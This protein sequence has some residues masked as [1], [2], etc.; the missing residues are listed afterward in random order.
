MGTYS[1]SATTQS[2]PIG[3]AANLPAI[4]GKSSARRPQ[5]LLS[6]DVLRGLTVALMIL[7]NNAGD[8]A[9]SYAQLRHSVWNG[10]TV[11]DLVFPLFLFIVGAS[12]VLAFG[13]RLDRGA[14]RRTILLQLGKRSA[15]IALI[16]LLLNALPFFDLG[17]LRYYGVMQRIALCYALAGTIY[18]A[19]RVKASVAAAILLLTLYWWLLTHVP[20]PGA[21]M[22]GVTIG[23]LDKFGNLTAWLDRLLIPAAHLY[24]HSVY[25]PEG[26]LSTLPAVASTLLGVLAAA[27]LRN[28]RPVRQK[29]VVLFAAGILLLNGGLVWSQSFPLN[30]RLWTSSFVLFTA[31][32]SAALL[33]AIY[34]LVDGPL[35][36]RRGLTPWQAFGTNAL[37][38]YVLSEVL[39]IVIGAIALP[40]GRNLQQLLYS[41]LPRWLG[42]APTV[43]LIYSILF[44]VACYLP[45][46]IL[47]RKRIF[48]KL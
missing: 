33:A 8:G 16:G 47:Y 21:G 40:G 12:I 2:D 32:L 34:W 35:Q 41:L 9:V 1:S 39:A 42:P 46:L 28:D 29:A 4:S 24:H 37:T 43:S 20:V 27:W 19:G 26:L 18:L 48:I 38:A 31:G 44:V 3:G 10:C 25:D 5:R 22:P 7:V 11:T 6:L 30:K 23:I 15:L 36:L 13:T 45:L 17:N 14:S